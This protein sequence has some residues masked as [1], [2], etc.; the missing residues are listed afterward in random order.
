MS[1]SM[2]TLAL[3][4][5][6]LA[7]ALCGTTAAGALRGSLVSES[8]VLPPVDLNDQKDVIDLEL[9]KVF[10]SRI[11]TIGDHEAQSLSNLYQ[12][13]QAALH[14]KQQKQ[15]RRIYENESETLYPVLPATIILNRQSERSSK[16]NE[17]RRSCVEHDTSDGL[18]R[19]PRDQCQ[20][21]NDNSDATKVPGSLNPEAQPWKLCCKQ[22]CGD[23]KKI[24][25]V[26]PFQDTKA[27][28]IV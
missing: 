17:K 3:A 2:P 1:F 6:L 25:I 21:V 13:L 14:Q 5:A 9:G 28:P 16:H 26:I 15:G 11:Q 12:L 19:T 7:A 18:S 27:T 4:W 24:T 10:R 8:V 20:R 23:A 22:Q